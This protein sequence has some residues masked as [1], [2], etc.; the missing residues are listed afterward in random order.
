MQTYLTKVNNKSALY[1][2]H[3]SEFMQ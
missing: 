1:N 3:Q 2:E